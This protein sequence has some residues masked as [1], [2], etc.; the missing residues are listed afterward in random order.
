MELKDI[1][2]VSGQP[3]L[4]RYLAKS[5]NGIIV[6]SLLTGNRTNYP[7]S[8]RISSLAEIAIY[9]D[10]EDVPLW[11]VL[12]AMYGKYNGPAP[13]TPKSDPADQRKTMAEVL[14]EYDRERVHASDIKKLIA[15]YNLL[16]ENGMTDFTVEEPRKEN[17]E[18]QPAE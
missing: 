6:E 14:P 18:E 2:S 4:F 7:S 5:A 15:W 3:G 17:A 1:L 8:A 10:A 16:V 12:N 9:T 11:K 13:V